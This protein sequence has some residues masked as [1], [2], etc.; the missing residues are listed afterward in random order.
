VPGLGAG[1]P[2]HQ[3]TGL[4]IGQDSRDE[5]RRHQRPGVGTRWLLSSYTV[6]PFGADYAF[7]YD[8]HDL[9]GNWY[10]PQTTE[11]VKLY[12]TTDAVSS[13][14]VSDGQYITRDSISISAGCSVD[15]ELQHANDVGWTAVPTKH[16]CIEGR[17]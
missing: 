9:V 12:C 13:T 5:K 16:K 8:K 7:V 6:P 1:R 11:D 15:H 4:C 3:D 17:T 2:R 14:T 10:D